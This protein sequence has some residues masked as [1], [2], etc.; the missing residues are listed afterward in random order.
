MLYGCRY[1]STSA[2]TFLDKKLRQW[3]RRLL[4]WSSRS[5]GAVVL[6]DLS[7]YALLTL[8]AP[9]GVLPHES[10]AMR[11]AKNTP[12][13]RKSVKICGIVVSMRRMCGERRRAAAEEL[14]L[15]GDV[16]ACTRL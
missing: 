14:W 5:P 15:P 2:V 3:G 4:R 1:L 7:C 12:G 13:L 9:T 11:Q 6:G 16:I 10:F 8:L